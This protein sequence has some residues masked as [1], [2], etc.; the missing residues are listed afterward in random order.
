MKQSELLQLEEL[1]QPLY[2]IETWNQN[3]DDILRET[4]SIKAAVK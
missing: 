4:E 2:V 1:G 3:I